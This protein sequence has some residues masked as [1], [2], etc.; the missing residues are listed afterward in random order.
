MSYETQQA[1]QL[2]QA[3]NHR[4]AKAGPGIAYDIS[5]RTSNRSRE[6][7]N[8]PIIEKHNNTSRTSEDVIDGKCPLRQPPK[9]VVV[10]EDFGSVITPE[11]ELTYR[12]ISVQ[13]CRPKATTRTG[14]KLAITL[15]TAAQAQAGERVLV[16]A[17]LKRYTRLR[18]IKSRLDDSA[19]F[20]VYLETTKQDIHAI[21]NHQVCMGR[22]HARGQRT[23]WVRDALVV[24]IIQQDCVQSV[25]LNLD[26][27]EYEIV[28][29]A[30][31]SPRQQP[32]YL[33]SGTWGEIANPTNTS[34][35]LSDLVA[36][37]FGERGEN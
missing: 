27:E 19:A 37:K 30:E 26:G 8:N 9:G 22:I 33:A 7:L 5:A 31:L 20:A 4:A 29:D 34:P 16:T 28:L 12:G 35:R 23:A 11:R 25:V 1:E 6:Q 10:H 3:I 2:L 32:L 18:E 24:G 36:V 14:I 17:E 15:Q 13:H 21:K